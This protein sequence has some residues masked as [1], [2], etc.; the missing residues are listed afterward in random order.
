MEFDDAV[1]VVRKRPRSLT[2]ARTDSPQY[3]A[4]HEGATRQVGCATARSVDAKDGRHCAGG[5]NHEY[6][7]VGDGQSFGIKR[8]ICVIGISRYNRHWRPAIGAYKGRAVGPAAPDPDR[9]AGR[10]AAS[11]GE[12]RILY[13]TIRPSRL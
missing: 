13:E 1:G 9:R 12:D 2:A 5:E 10:R 11:E 8:I 7:A 4:G 6:T 3:R